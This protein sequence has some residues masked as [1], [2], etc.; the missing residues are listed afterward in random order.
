MARRRIVIFEWMTADGYFAGSDGNLDWVVPDDAQSRAAATEIGHFDTVLFG[1]RT[2][3]QFAGFWPRVLEQA[4]SGSVPDPHHP[5]RRSRDH[6]TVATAMD[7]MT[8]LVFSTTLKD[9]AWRNSRIMRS[10]DA[11]EIASLKEQP[12]KDMIVFGSGSIVSQLTEHRLIDEY[13][14]L[15][16]PVFLGNGR[17]LFRDVSRPVRLDLVDTARYASGD[18]MIRY[19]RAT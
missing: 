8:K 19:K 4:D 3:E 10:F 14:F 9:A 13:Q 18:V 2:Y 6:Y 1:R 7:A 11:G 5:D 17:P 15:T 16:C 12:G